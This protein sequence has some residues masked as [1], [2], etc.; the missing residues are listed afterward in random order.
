MDPQW[1]LQQ[2]KRQKQYPGAEVPRQERG[3]NLPNLGMA[4]VY[5]ADS[6]LLEH[7]LTWTSFFAAEATLEA[8][9]QKH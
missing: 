5:T 8:Q 4:C 3:G 2:G 7:T 6:S 9:Q 1:R